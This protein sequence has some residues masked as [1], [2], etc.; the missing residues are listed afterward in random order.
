MS[1]ERDRVISSMEAY[2]RFM[3][4]QGKEPSAIYVTKSQLKTLRSAAGE[5]DGFKPRYKGIEVRAAE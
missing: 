2:L 3:R 5:K 1:T 4:S